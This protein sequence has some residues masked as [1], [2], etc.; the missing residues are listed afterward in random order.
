MIYWHSQCASRQGQSTEHT[1]LMAIDSRMKSIKNVLKMSI[2]LSKNV[3]HMIAHMDRNIILKKLVKETASTISEV[4]YRFRELGLRKELIC[5]VQVKTKKENCQFQYKETYLK[6]HQKDFFCYENRSFVI[7]NA[8]L[9][10]LY[11]YWTINRRRR[12]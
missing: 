6:L 3:L 1:K 2:N 9:H 5:C 12:K 4:G 11:Q 10:H 8:F 7:V